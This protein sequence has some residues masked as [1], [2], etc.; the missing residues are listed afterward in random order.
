MLVLLYDMH[1]VVKDKAN[2]KNIKIFANTPKTSFREHPHK[3]D[4]TMNKNT[5]E[6]GTGKKMELFSYK[7]TGVQFHNAN[8]TD[9]INHHNTL[10]RNQT[11]T[12]PPRTGISANVVTAHLLERA[13]E[14]VTTDSMQNV[15]K[16]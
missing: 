8:A 13:T 10:G 1:V 6:F 9:I 16:M 12:R 4:R 2:K 11:V 14:R 15:T 7:G 3:N 5:S